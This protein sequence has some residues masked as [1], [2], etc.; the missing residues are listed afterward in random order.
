MNKKIVICLISTIVIVLI[1][2]GII[3][4]I[5]VN[6][7]K[8]NELNNNMTTVNDNYD[9]LKINV[10]TFNENR[11]NVYSN[12]LNNFYY[13]E[14]ENNYNYWNEYFNNYEKSV[15]DI[16]NIIASLD[17]VCNIEYFDNNVNKKCIT[18]KETYENVIN[19]FVT[20]INLY[21]KQLNEYNNWIKE[22]KIEKELVSVYTSKF[23]YIDYNN[24]KV[25]SGKQDE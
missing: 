3:S 12:V 7:E 1:S 8:Q 2:F 14:V 15:I 4:F 18:Y 16:E 5:N 20:D 24:D 13:E 22:E 19:T 21:N 11:I 25:Y 6:K 17:K 9:K 10:N 23:K